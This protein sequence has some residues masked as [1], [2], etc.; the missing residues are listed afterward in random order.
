ML[1]SAYFDIIKLIF[2]F[3]T[4]FVVLFEL[5]IKWLIAENSIFFTIGKFVLPFYLIL[6]WLIL[7]YIIWYIKSLQTTG[8]D[9][10]DKSYIFGFI[11][12]WIIGLI[13]SVVYYFFIN[14]SL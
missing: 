13:F 9:T 10:D 5:R 8:T 4:I 2:F 3:V 12:G 6:L 14:P 7:G 1:M 11:V